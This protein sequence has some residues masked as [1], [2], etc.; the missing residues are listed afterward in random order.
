MGRILTAVRAPQIGLKE[1]RRG[2]ALSESA[3]DNNKLTECTTKRG[4]AYTT[5][6]SYCSLVYSDL[7]S[8]RMRMSGSASFQRMKKSL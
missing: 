7:A 8:F 4:T 1:S 6:F 3:L 2:L 5:F